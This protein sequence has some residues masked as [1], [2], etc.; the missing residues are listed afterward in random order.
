MTSFAHDLQRRLDRCSHKYVDASLAKFDTNSDG[1]L[2]KVEMRGL[3][4]D[5]LVN[6][7]AN[8]PNLARESVEPA[9]ESLKGW[10][11]HDST[12]PM[13]YAKGGSMHVVM[14]MSSQKR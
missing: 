3:V 7:E 9:V 14:E 8:L 2:D 11:E 10:I 12:G 6:I 4:K 13:G 5:V 1:V